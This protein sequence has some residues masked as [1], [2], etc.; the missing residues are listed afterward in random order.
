MLSHGA[1]LSPFW[2]DLGVGQIS[3][4]TIFGRYTPLHPFPAFLAFPF[5]TR[6]AL[7]TPS[8]LLISIS[9]LSPLLDLSSPSI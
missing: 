7:Y 9:G 8:R 6:L 4:V 3:D 2:A 1:W 5:S